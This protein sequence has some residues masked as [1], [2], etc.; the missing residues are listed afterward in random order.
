MHMSIDESGDQ[1]EPVS[2]DRLGAARCA[3]GPGGDLRSFDA[4]G[5]HTRSRLRELCAGDPEHATEISRCML[6]ACPTKPMS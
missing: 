3:G 4:K 2:V 5:R 1:D 6:D